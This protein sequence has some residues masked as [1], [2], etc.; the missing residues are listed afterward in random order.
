MASLMY[1][2]QCIHCGRSAFVDNYYKTGA[3]YIKCYRC[4]YS[5]SKKVTKTDSFEVKEFLGYGVYN[6]VK[7]TGHGEFTFI[8]SPIT[9]QL[10]EEFYLE[11]LKDDVDK[12]NCY[13]VSYESGSFYVL[14]GTPTENFYL[15]FDQYKEKMEE[16]YGVD[17]GN[18]WFIAIEH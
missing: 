7:K 13:L 3:K 9:D 8:Q 10:K 18:E 5:Y 2:Q 16:K 17:N 1:A 15:T 11:L 4:G 14:F 12:E 6:L